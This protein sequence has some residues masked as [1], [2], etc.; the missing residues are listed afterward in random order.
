MRSTASE[1]Y[2]DIYKFY[3]VNKIL[4]PIWL[5][6]CFASVRVYHYMF[7]LIHFLTVAIK[8]GVM[9]LLI[10]FCFCSLAL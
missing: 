9:W 7:S 1:S 5:R 3:L 10:L 8:L 6:V 4:M 2:E